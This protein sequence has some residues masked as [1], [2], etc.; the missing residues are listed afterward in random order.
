[1]TA[2]NDRLK[3]GPIPGSNEN[4][5][6][7]GSFDVFIS[8]AHADND[9]P[10][11]GDRGWVDLLYEAL[12][13]CLRGHLGR[14]PR[15]FLD[16]D[17]QLTGSSVLTP[18]IT[19]ALGGCALL[20]PIVSKS[21]LASDWCK[22]ELAEFMHVAQNSGG[23]MVGTK[24]RVLKAIKLPVGIGEPHTGIAAVDEALGYPFYQRLEN[25]TP[26][27]P[28]A[29]LDPPY[30][31]NLGTEFGKQINQLAFD[32]KELIEG[33]PTTGSERSNRPIVYLAD[34]STDAQN[35]RDRIRSELAQFGC[36]VLPTE[37]R[38]PGADYGVRVAS[39]L[40]Q[41]RFSVHVI[42]NSYGVV[43]EDA[44][45][46]IVAM[47]YNLAGEE[48]AKRPQFRRML[49]M[50]PGTQP[51]DPRQQAFVTSLHSDPELVVTPL[52]EF[53]TLLHQQLVPPATLAVS[54]GD[55]EVK[56]VYLIFD[57]S[58]E[59]AA[60]AADRWL[61]EHH[62]E[63]IKPAPGTE[64]RSTEEHTELLR[65]CEGVLFYHGHTT[66][67]WLRMNLIKLQKAFATADGKRAECA[68]VLADPDSKE[69]RGFRSN[70]VQFV[71]PGFGAFSPEKLTAF[72][73]ALAGRQEPA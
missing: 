37:S 16:R 71:I 7:D 45:E 46:S 38:W 36:D 5:R 15:I 29:P 61:Y 4:I 53:K 32:I 28:P 56:N 49:W 9:Y 8:Y 17:G 22:R 19:A 1:M 10:R 40:A 59:D 48:H 2:A 44:T 52:E 6:V 47:Q 63:V 31:T 33:A 58:D 70:L 21:Y 3:R 66:E 41:A 68:V 65:A 24:T 26:V 20:V 64:T 62:F 51:A 25:G 39:D 55:D 11:Y 23:I 14:E 42:G 35:D 34:T 43:P 50:S 18:A 60:E 12:K 54:S 13:P 72:A 73:D 69:K 57:P 67:T 30:S 27:M